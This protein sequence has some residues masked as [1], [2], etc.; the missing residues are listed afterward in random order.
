MDDAKFLR[1]LRL[2]GCDEAA[3]RIESDAIKIMHMRSVL[4]EVRYQMTVR[5]EG[6]KWRY[7]IQQIDD[8]LTMTKKEVNK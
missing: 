6:L 5:G 7:E 1:A 4:Q 2:D 8:A 3:D